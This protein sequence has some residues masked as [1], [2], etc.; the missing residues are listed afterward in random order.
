MT[1]FHDLIAPFI[2]R[3]YEIGGPVEVQKVTAGEVTEMLDKNITTLYRR[4]RSGKIKGE[5]VNRRWEMP[6][7]QFPPNLR[8]KYER[9]Q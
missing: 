7:D 3:P 6:I 8:K 4:L 1:A 2:P 9:C 5:K